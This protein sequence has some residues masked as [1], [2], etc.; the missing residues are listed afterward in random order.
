MLLDLCSGDEEVLGER[1]RR[2]IG[3]DFYFSIRVMDVRLRHVN[4]CLV[5]FDH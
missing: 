5:L 4:G 2:D 3:L 1:D